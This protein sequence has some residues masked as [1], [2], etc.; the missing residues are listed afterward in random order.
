MRRA[1]AMGL[2]SIG[3]GLIG[4][5]VMGLG[6]IFAIAAG[7]GVPAA[8]GAQDNLSGTYEMSGISLKPDSPAYA[9]ECKL[10][11]KGEVYDVDCINA[12]SLD[13]NKGKGLRRSEQF[14]L[15]LGEYLVVYRIGADGTL[16]GNW[17]H[18]ESNDYG[19]ETLKPRK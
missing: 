17:A 15:Y 6:L 1:G 12:G 5:G 9:G 8:Q 10:E 16:D 18:A 13:R 11:L 19:K 2:G 4:L 14:S 7:I 3:L